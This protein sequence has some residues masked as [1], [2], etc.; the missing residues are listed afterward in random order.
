MSKLSE[1]QQCAI[2]AALVEGVSIRSVE[3]L[4]GH[5]RDSV[6]RLGVKVGE[7]CAALH[8]QLMR[9]LHVGR[10]EMQDPDTWG[11]QYI[12]LAMDG[13]GKAILSWLI[14]KRSY[15][16]TQHL[17]DDLRHRLLNEPEISTDGF[18]AYPR[19]VELAFDGQAAH[20]QRYRDVCGTM[21]VL[22]RIPNLFPRP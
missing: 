11:D 18:H 7:G 2:I 15:R 13:T 14:G 6:M 22:P 5:H 16:N 17:L 4:H 8:G 12:F 20:P 1:K 9:N 21:L 19:A 10:V 3:R